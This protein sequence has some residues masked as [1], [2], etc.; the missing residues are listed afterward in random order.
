MTNVPTPD[1]QQ[2][3]AARK[4]LDKLP[5]LGPAVWLF[6]R[7]QQR[8]FTFMSDI[9]WRLIPPMVLDQCKAYTKMDLPWAFV[10]WA[11]VSDVVHE[12]LLKG[13]VI[14]PVE[15]RTGEHLWLIDV[16][17]PFGDVDNVAIETIA[18]IDPT[19]IAHAWLPLNNGQ[20]ILKEFRPPKLTTSI[21]PSQIQ[22]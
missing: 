10:T 2:L 8:R 21:A 22:H 14:A 9:D 15:W 6:A 12:R 5:L 20:S 16:V 11:L 13:S 19:K 18:A 1:P 7:D 17:A 3:A 4:E